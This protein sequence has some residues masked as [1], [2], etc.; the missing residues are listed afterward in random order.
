MTI[1]ETAISSIQNLPDNATW[2]D[3]VEQINFIAGVKK[4]LS[5]LDKGKGIAHAQVME[6]FREWLSN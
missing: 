1:K 3:I 4:G 2:E 5:E 6:E